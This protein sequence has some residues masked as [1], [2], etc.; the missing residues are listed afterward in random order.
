ML[1]R[2]LNDTENPEVQAEAV[3]AMTAFLSANDNSPQLMGQFKDLIP[4]MIQVRGGVMQVLLLSHNP[5]FGKFSCFKII[6]SSFYD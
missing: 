3:K 4:P 5:V 2:C 1:S 6:G